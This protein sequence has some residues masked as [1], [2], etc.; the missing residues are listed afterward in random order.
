MQSTN[1]S[2][3]SLCITPTMV[4]RVMAE[5][6]SYHTLV[7]CN[8]LTPL[9]RSVLDLSYK[10]FLHVMQQLVRFWLTYHITRSVC[11]SSDSCLCN[12]HTHYYNSQ[13]RIFET[14]T[15]TLWQT[16]ISLS[17]LL[18]LFL[19]CI[20]LLFLLW[21]AVFYTGA[22]LVERKIMAEKQYSQLFLLRKSCFVSKGLKNKFVHELA[23]F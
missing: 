12:P 1:S 23:N 13:H 2:T 4:A 22:L 11:G 21:D 16:V 9:L 20:V 18:G 7:N 19:H 10:L 5:C 17:Y 8:P 15:P 3:V 6:T 14:L